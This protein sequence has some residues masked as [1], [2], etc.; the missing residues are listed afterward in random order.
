M[1]KENDP[2]KV[3][4]DKLSLRGLGFFVEKDYLV[5]IFKKTEKLATAL[6][7][8]TSFF[9]DDEPLKWTLREKGMFLLSHALVVNDSDAF[10]RDNSLRNIFSTA[11]EIISLLTVASAS[12]LISEMNY[13][14]LKREFEF[15]I[16]KLR[17]SIELE[18]FDRGFV[19]S[20]TFF[21]TDTSVVAGNSVTDELRKIADSDYKGHIKNPVSPNHE[22]FSFRTTPQALNVQNRESLFRPKNMSNSVS[23][24]AKSSV[25]DKKNDRRD[26]IVKLL[27]NG[28]SLTVKDFTKVI[29][30]CSEKTIQRELLD[31]VDKGVLKKEGERRWSRYSLSA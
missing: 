25:K 29:S 28:G 31:L 16:N 4:N 13:T 1:N 20:N 9:K 14:I 10:D 2:N 21:E 26:R 23:A 12:K 15:L 5:F 22:Q 17:E 27:S 19:L 30:E 24:S 3:N 7:L 11:L 8:V 6:Y 18:T